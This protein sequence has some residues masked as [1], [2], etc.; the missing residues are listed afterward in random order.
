MYFLLRGASEDEQMNMLYYSGSTHLLL[1][2]LHFDALLSP[3]F[4]LLNYVRRT[5]ILLWLFAFYMTPVGVVHLT[6]LESKH[7]QCFGGVGQGVILGLIAGLVIYV[8]MLE[9]G[10][11]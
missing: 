11:S 2:L 10:F 6:V 7:N 4:Y 1:L 5:P 9:K 3:N 8:G